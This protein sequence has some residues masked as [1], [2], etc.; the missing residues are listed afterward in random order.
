MTLRKLDD[1]TVVSRIKSIP[2]VIS[3]KLND[4]W[5]RVIA[6]L[7]EGLE[8]PKHSTIIKQALAIAHAKVLNDPQTSKILEIIFENKRKNKRLGYDLEYE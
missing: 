6:E 1:G 4:D 8:Q 5:K 3:V 2:D 7:E